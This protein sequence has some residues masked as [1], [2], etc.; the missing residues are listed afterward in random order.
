MKPSFWGHSLTE[1]EKSPTLV[2]KQFT[3]AALFISFEL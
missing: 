3:V 2:K 1:F